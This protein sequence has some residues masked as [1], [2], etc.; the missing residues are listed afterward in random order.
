[1]REAT[2]RNRCGEVEAPE[3]GLVGEVRLQTHVQIG[4]VGLGDIEVFSLDVARQTVSPIAVRDVV[5]QRVVGVPE[6]VAVFQFARV[7]VERIL[8]IVIVDDG[9]PAELPLTAVEV[10]L[11]IV[12]SFIATK[13]RIF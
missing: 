9:A 4:V 10:L 2:Q 8:G 5:A 1:M 13:L 6:V 7:D 12:F 11:N 3:V